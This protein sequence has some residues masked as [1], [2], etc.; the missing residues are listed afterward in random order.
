MADKMM[1][2]DVVAEFLQRCEVDTA[3]GV[4][5]VHNIPMLDAIGRRN[6]IQFVMGRGEAGAGSMADAYARTRGQLGVLF[7]STGPGAANACGAL[8]E[9]RFAGSPVLHITGQTV[10]AHLDKGRG[11]VHDVPDQL[12]MLRSVSKAAYR[13]ESAEGALG[14]LLRAATEALTPPAGP[15]SVE[16]PIDIQRRMIDRPELLDALRVAPPPPLP[17]DP[18]AVEL[19]AAMVAKAK[20]PML[21]CGNGA[22]HAG[23]A[24]ARLADMGVAIV[25]SAAGRG[26][27]PEDH[28]MTLGAF[29]ATPEVE[30]FYATVDLMIVAGSRLRGHETREFDLKL[31]ERRAQIDVDPAALGRTYGSDLFVQGDSASVLDELADRLEGRLQVEAGYR[32]EIARLGRETRAA[33]RETLGPYKTFPEQF[34]EAMP[35]DALWVRD[36]TLSNTTWGNRL[37]PVYGPR[38]SVY[39]VGA[40]IGLAVGLAVGAAAANPGRKTVCLTGD[41]GFFLNIAELYAAVQEKL[42]I[43]FVVMN[44]GG[45][46]VIKHIQDT[47]HEGR[48][49]NADLQ[50]PDLEGLAKLSGMHFGRISR[51]DQVKDV[52]SAAVAA[53]GPALVE[54]DMHAIGPFPRYFVPPA[55]LTKANS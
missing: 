2:A 52:I 36:V 42:D 4:T 40:G 9:A 44:D 30:A 6:A 33:F 12:G 10:T 45:Y 53:E 14:I 28:P 55:S 43:A 3:F 38:D 41:G 46:G 21:W 32:E 24:V 13:I 47:F 35:R 51:A 48:H 18:G 19:L 22:R 26:V 23:K 29:N 5:S 17:A 15:V 37:F 34:R 11:T 27:L 7:T 8:V 39:P 49:Y 50:N 1:V 20:R 25:T 16:I 31:P 54:V